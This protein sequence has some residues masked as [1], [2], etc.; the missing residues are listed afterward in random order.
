MTANQ[1]RI[2]IW[3]ALGLLIAVGLLFAFMP[4]AVT[5]DLVTIAPGPMVVT[6]D[7][8]G[9]TRVHDVFVLSAPVAGRVRRMEAHV[10]DA[11]V[12]HET[13]LAQIEPG[14]PTLLDPRSEAQAEAAL[15]AAESALDL[16]RAGVEQAVAEYEFAQGEYRRTRDLVAKG[17]I[18][19]RDAEAAERAHKTRRAAL[20][21]AQAE[22]QMR[23]FQLQQAQAQL[24]SPVQLQK[25]HGE[26]ECVDVTAPVSGRVL[27]IVNPSERIVNAGDALV[28]I[29]NPADLEIVIDFLSTDAVQIESGQRVIIERWGGERA[30][31]GRVRRVEPFGYAKTSALGI[32]EQRVNVIVDLTSPFAEWSRLGHGYQVDARV[33]LWE[34]EQALTVPLTAM[35]RQGEDWALFVNDDGRAALRTIEIG[36][37]NG[38][39]AEV[40]SGLEPGV[41]VVLHPSDRVVESVRI[42]ARG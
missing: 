12:A 30:L 36:K 6:A 10:G 35:F 18:S 5:V 41:Q 11:V 2:M 32:E 4:R 31:S 16:A 39:A 33:V 21:T 20:A 23:T 26:C 3:A 9:K 37:R 24:M 34:T 28:E 25:T 38:I 22:V 27:K 40:T 42:R 1:K 15:H 17:T 13:V 14:D 7:E 19:V 29:G 8:E